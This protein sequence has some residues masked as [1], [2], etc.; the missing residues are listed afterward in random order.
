MTNYS[1]APIV[2]QN[3]FFKQN[4]IEKSTSS[5]E[6]LRYLL[7]FNDRGEIVSKDF[8][9]EHLIGKNYHTVLLYKTQNQG[10]EIFVIETKNDRGEVI[11][12]KEVSPK[13]G[14]HIEK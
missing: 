4:L 11:C 8:I 12:L 14:E 1:I 13:Y 3:F 10:K 6:R 9:E 2:L 7:T 5:G